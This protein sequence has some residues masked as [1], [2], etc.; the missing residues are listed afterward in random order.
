MDESPGG[1]R[2][3]VGEGKKLKILIA[4]NFVVT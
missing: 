4:H 2:G 1:A 3:R